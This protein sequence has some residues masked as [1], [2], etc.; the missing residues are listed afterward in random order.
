MR[1]RGSGPTFPAFPL[2]GSRTSRAWRGADG[3]SR[4][5][6]VIRAGVGLSTNDDGVAAAAEAA[7]AARER[8]GGRADFCVAFVSSGHASSFPEA[9]RSLSEAAGTPYVVGCSA[10][11]VIAEG[12]EVEGGPAL[13]VLAVASDS[14]R[15]TPFLFRDDG[16][17]GLTAGIHLGQ[18]LVASRGAEDLVA[19]WPDPYRI[20]PVRLLQGLDA[21][22]GGVQVAGGAAS[23]TDGTGRTFQFSGAEMS[24][25]AVSGLRLGGPFR[26]RILVSQ[27]CAAIGG[28]LRITRCHENL[29]LE[30]DGRP[31]LERLREVV[32]ESFLE[33]PKLR[34]NAVSVALLPADGSP[35]LR[36]GEYL[37]RSIVG[38]DPDTGAL[39]V[40]DVVEEGQR[41]VFAVR[42]PVSARSELERSLASVRGERWSFA[43][44]FDCLGR[45]RS[46]YGAA[47]VDVGL[48]GRYLPGVP[49][50]GF[51]CNA[52]IAPLRGLNYLFTFTGVL[53]LVGA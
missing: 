32:S 45:G 26:R 46:L 31:A 14:L 13:G 16:D 37:V 40:A 51:F 1:G 33:D 39:G 52:E 30:L 5:P 7:T 3:A 34:A 9:L 53:V 42:E 6:F 25:S 17:Q 20:H 38:A 35:E 11:G 22:L 28:P 4:L 29:V 15:A 44:Y 36:P 43:L 48:I 8:A 19:V 23:A 10:A 27:G 21:A 12:R 50:L 41:I 18:R 49:L 24:S 2:H 47:G